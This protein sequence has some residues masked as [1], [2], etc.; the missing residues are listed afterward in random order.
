MSLDVTL[1]YLINGLAGRSKILDAVARLFVNEYF[2]PTTM[3]LIVL[4]LWFA[5]NEPAR[6]AL[7]Q[8]MFFQTAL[9]VLLSNTALKGVNLL[10]FR[11]RPFATLDVTRCFYEPWDS[12]F[13]SN[14]A[15]VGF[16]VATA[17]YLHHRQAG[18][19]MYGLAAA[20]ALS[21]VYCGVHYPLD[22]VAGALLGSVSAV[23]VVRQTGF[24]DPFWDW[25]IG[26]GRRLHLA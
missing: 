26:V 3:A 21:R 18:L 24:L 8:R 4:V 25:L 22:I 12:S 10:Y 7:H 9:A 19:V 1:F 5:P 13:P 11:P 15:T 16:A 23:I 14:P 6:R 17:V 2:V 20:F